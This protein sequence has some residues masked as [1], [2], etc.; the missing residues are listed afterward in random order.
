LINI[1]KYIEHSEPRFDP[2]VFPLETAGSKDLEYEV[3][4]GPPPVLSAQKKYS[5]AH[6][7]SLFLS[8]ELTPLDVVHA[9]LP[10]IRRDTSPPGQHS[11]AWFNIKV[12]LVL[13]AAEASTL[14]YK[15][16]RSL[17]PLDGVPAAVKDEFDMEGY[18]T[19]LGSVNDYT[20]QE[21][22]EGKIDTW[23]VRK[24]EEAGVIILGKLSM[25]EFGM[26]QL[27]K[28]LDLSRRLPV[29]THLVTIS[30]MEPRAT[31]TTNNT[32]QVVALPDPL[33]PSRLALSPYRWAVT[34]AAASASPRLSALSS[35]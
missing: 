34:A 26:G 2:T 33:T 8:G 28:S 6:Y 19:S 25:H 23:C 10:L 29:Q 20:G 30:Y 17:G 4:S 18:M 1:R 7:R 16:K 24:L 32:I 31:L 12:D 5:V 22:I 3:E 9:I 21:L 35:A 11:M 14:R 13:K 27:P 15:E